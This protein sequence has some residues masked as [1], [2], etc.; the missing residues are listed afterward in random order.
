MLCLLLTIAQ[1]EEIIWIE[2][3]D[4]PNHNFQDHSWFNNVNQ[5]L[6]SPGIPGVLDGDWLVHYKMGAGAP[7]AQ[8]WETIQSSVQHTSMDGTPTKT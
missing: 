2:G 5:D 1:A 4:S 8:A 6:L 7:N 3:E